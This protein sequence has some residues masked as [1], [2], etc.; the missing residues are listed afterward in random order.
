MMQIFSTSRPDINST[1]KSKRF[2]VEQ[3]VRQT[4]ET[5]WRTEA[6][7]SYAQPLLLW[8][9]R[10]QGRITISGVTHG[11]GPHNAV[12]LPAGTMHG[13]AMLG[14]VFGT[15]VFF[16]RDDTLSLPETPV[17]YRF[18]EVH[19]QAELTGMIDNIAREIGNDLPGQNRALSAHAGLLSVW[20]DRQQT[21]E[22]LQELHPDAARKLAAAFASMVER[23]YRSGRSIQDYATRLGVTPTHLTRSCNTACGRSGSAILADRIHFEARTLL[24]ETRRPV[25]DIAKDLGF[26]SAAYFTRAFQKHTGQTPTEFRRRS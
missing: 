9:T 6:M 22:N 1:L 10:G 16:P 12:F 13:Y 23:D 17:H 5:R 15:S 14:Q 2:R 19:Q 11:F 24:V 8:F 21:E 20:L 4:P 25:K 3:L 26:S 7:R 18:R